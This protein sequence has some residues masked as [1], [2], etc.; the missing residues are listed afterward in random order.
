MIRR[1]QILAA[2]SAASTSASP[3]PRSASPTDPPAPARISRT[4]HPPSQA[5]GPHERIESAVLRALGRC[6]KAT[7]MDIVRNVRGVEVLIRS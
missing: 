3:A 2:R 4:G 1:R 7:P 6:G 5:G